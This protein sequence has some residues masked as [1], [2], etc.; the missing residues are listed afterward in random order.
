MSKGSVRSPRKNQV[1]I[2]VN[3]PLELCLRAQLGRRGRNQVRIAV[4]EPLEALL[5]ARLGRQG[6]DQVTSPN[7]IKPLHVI[8]N[9]KLKRFFFALVQR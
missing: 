9:E 1:R 3:E 5:G 4:I 7:Q 8:A 2:A 6:R